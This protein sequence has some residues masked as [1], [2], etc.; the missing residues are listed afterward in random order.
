MAG[1]PPVSISGKEGAPAVSQDKTTEV[2]AYKGGKIEYDAFEWNFGYAPANSTV[3]HTYLIKNTG[4]DTL[5]ITNVKPS[6]GCTSAPLLKDVLGPGESTGLEVGFKTLKFIGE[7]KKD[8]R[9]T[10]S[11][12]NGSS[13]KIVFSANI[14][15]PHPALRVDPEIIDF[16]QIP[17]GQKSKLVTKLTNISNSDLTLVTIDSPNKDY[18]EY[19]FKRDT[20][21]PNQS[22]ELEV[23]ISEKAPV[24]ILQ[25]SITL[26]VKPL[27]N[28]R[29]SIPI[30]G[31]IIP[32]R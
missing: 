18:L 3:K 16:V 20:L 22:T 21:K 31:E 27:T 23:R 24:G 14:S 19:K 10:S 7:V 6:C 29:L 28:A 5:R 8:V 13:S 25:E 2:E 15:N 4:T 32:G 9:I 12:P 30:R 26:D 1:D 17:I 11:D